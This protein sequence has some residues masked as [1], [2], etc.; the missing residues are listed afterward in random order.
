MI[1]GVPLRRT[2]GITQNR[3]AAL[4]RQK[5]F[6]HEQEAKEIHFTLNGCLPGKKFA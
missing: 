6:I 3:R 4:I 5:L 1:P 2:G